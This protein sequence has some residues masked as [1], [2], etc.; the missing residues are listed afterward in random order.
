VLSTHDITWASSHLWFVRDLGNGS[1]RVRQTY[2][3]VDGTEANDE[4][5][6]GDVEELARWAGITQNRRKDDRP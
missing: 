3:L 1:V 4:R 2:R 6:F 5:V